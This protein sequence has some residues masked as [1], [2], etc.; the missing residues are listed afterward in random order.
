MRWP[1]QMAQDTAWFAKEEEDRRALLKSF[2]IH[3]CPSSTCPV[4]ILFGSLVKAAVPRSSSGRGSSHCASQRREKT[5]KCSSP[6]SSPP[7]PPIIAAK[8]TPL[9]HVKD[10]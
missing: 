3:R 1:E 9:P 10:L 2:P 7:P 6:A 4:I 8:F 5:K